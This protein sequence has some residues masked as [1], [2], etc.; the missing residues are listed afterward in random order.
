MVIK[1]PE[2]LFI[3]I[4]PVLI[5]KQVGRISYECILPNLQWYFHDGLNGIKIQ[6]AIPCMCILICVF[7]MFILFLLYGLAMVFYA[8]R[9][10]MLLPCP[11]LVLDSSS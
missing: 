6:D 11:S 3:R 1:T 4:Q 10:A 7:L 2:L 5:L 9:F 8:L